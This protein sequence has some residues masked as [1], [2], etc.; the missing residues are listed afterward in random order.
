MKKPLNIIEKSKHIK[1]ITNGVYAFESEE[2]TL[3]ENEAMNELY[4]E[5][6]Y[7]FYA[8]SDFFKCPHCKKISFYEPDK[9]NNYCG[10]C[11]FV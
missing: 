4:L 2:V 1:P 3:E 9:T 5:W 11:G 8:T 6:D 10:Q 7:C